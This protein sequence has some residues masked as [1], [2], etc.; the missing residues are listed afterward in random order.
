MPGDELK[1]RQAYLRQQRDRL[2]AMKKAARAKQLGDADRTADRP[3]SSRL[4]RQAVAKTDV[5]TDDSGDG[6][7]AG[8]REEEKKLAMRRSLADKLRREV[9]DRH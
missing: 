4:A 3:Q 7:K 9:I 2:L 1:A 6:R 5:I 8:A